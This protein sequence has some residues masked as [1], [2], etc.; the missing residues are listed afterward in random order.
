VIGLEAAYVLAEHGLKV[1]VAE[2]APYLMPRVL[3]RTSAEYLRRRMTLF[4][5]ITDARVQGILGRER[6]DAVALEGRDPIPA[7]VVLISCGVRANTALAQEAGLR[8]D[9]GVVVDAGMR[10]SDADIYACGNCAVYGGFSTGLW[11]EAVQQGRVAGSNAAGGRE[12][13]TGSDSS[14]MMCCSEFAL[15]SDGDLGMDP[16]KTYTR[17]ER[18]LS[19][20]DGYR[21]NPT[22]RTLFER[23]FYVDN[24]LVGVFML[25]DLRAMHQ[26]RRAL[27]G[28]DR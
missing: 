7:Q 21:V 6:A 5:T 13:Y 18:E 20:E 19:W 8:V 26:R 27:F 14:L 23:D 28:A 24:R 3:D 1:T 2:G 9:R 22:P 25:G 4:E 12:I 11:A 16:H 10:T 15:Y 17:T